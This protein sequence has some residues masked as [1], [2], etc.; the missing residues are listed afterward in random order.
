[1]LCIPINA[2]VARKWY[3]NGCHCDAH[4]EC[5]YYILYHFIVDVLAS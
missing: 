5:L 2:S 4:C 3:G 1:M